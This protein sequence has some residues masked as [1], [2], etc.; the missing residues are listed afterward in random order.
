MSE[1]NILLY[2]MGD[3]FSLMGDTFWACPPPPPPNLQKILLALIT[4][5]ITTA[6]IYVFLPFFKCVLNSRH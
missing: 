1:I 3:F 5:A 2:L 4:A 6:G